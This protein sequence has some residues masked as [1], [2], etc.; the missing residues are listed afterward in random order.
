MIRLKLLVM[1]CG[2]SALGGVARAEEKPPFDLSDPQRIEAG[3]GRFTSSCAGY[4][5]GFGG[6]GGNAPDFKGRGDELDPV[7]AFDTITNGRK[8]R[9]AVM[10]RWGDAY[11]PEQIWELVAYLEFLAHQKPEQPQ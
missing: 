7:F 6:V 5:H 8:G 3:K 4:C 10:P 9:R 11:S 1:L 2:L